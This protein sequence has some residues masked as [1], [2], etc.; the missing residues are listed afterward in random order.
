MFLLGRVAFGHAKAGHQQA[1]D[2]FG[3][4]I[5]TVGGSSG[6]WHCWADQLST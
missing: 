6:T 1:A 2:S 4:D 5:K 3:V